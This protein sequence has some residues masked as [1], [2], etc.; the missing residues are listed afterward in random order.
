M[1]DSVVDVYVR[2][3]GPTHVRHTDAVSSHDLSEALWVLKNANVGYFDVADVSRFVG[4]GR[5]R[6]N[7]G[8]AEA[9]ACGFEHVKS[10]VR[11]VLLW[12]E[13]RDQ[14]VADFAHDQE[15]IGF[16]DA[17]QKRGSVWSF[18]GFS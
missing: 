5:V 14:Q 8:T 13:F 1:I 10:P 16:A 11:N 2:T 12:S 7:C 18:A 6:P 9:L 3:S 15:A 17:G 4:I